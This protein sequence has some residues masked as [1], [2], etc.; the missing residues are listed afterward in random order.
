MA[1]LDVRLANAT[2]R[3]LVKLY[4]H[5]CRLQGRPWPQVFD[6]YGVLT[7]DRVLVLLETQF[8]GVSEQLPAIRTTSLD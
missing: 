6:S 4:P 7:I 5:S 8:G 1:S 3:L 2:S